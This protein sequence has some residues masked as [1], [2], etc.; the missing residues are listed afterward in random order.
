ME[1]ILKL[2]KG[3]PGR[4][5][6]LS[7]LF[8]LLLTGFVVILLLELPT[9]SAEPFC[10]CGDLDDDGDIDFDDYDIMIESIVTNPS[11]PDIL[12][13]DTDEDGVSDTLE[14]LVEAVAGNSVADK[15]DK[16][17]FPDVDCSGPGT[18]GAGFLDGDITN[19][20]NQGDGLG[21]DIYDLL[22][23]H[24]L[25]IG[26]SAFFGGV[27][28]I[29][30]KDIDG[31]G[32]L[33][34]ADTEATGADCSDTLDNNGNGD[35]DCADSDC[36]FFFTC[37][38]TETSCTDSVDNDEDTLTDC[39]DDDCDGVGTCEFATE[40]TCNDGLDNDGDGL[41][42]DTGDTCTDGSTAGDPDCAPVASVSR[43]INGVIGS[44]VVDD[45][46]QIDLDAVNIPPGSTTITE[47]VPPGWTVS[48]AGG[49][50]DMGSTLEFD[51]GGDI[52]IS[53]VLSIPSCGPAFSTHP[54]S[55]SYSGAAS[56]TVTGDTDIVC[57]SLGG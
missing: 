6:S 33:D 44:I 55:G 11:Y 36:S 43:T 25:A 22:F 56:G 41:C 30:I 9:V 42:D 46:V 57:P 18:S 3:D 8:T 45:T 1:D 34:S 48:D 26:E 53:Y 21:G 23:I 24:K 50:A 54:V 28:C 29:G 35:T 2:S 17:I 27:E 32:I 37:G 40:L 12:D 51:I 5:F 49:G 19:T 38:G 10:T 14:D 7:I 16:F 31:D 15:T 39:Q 52:M 4:I 13:D 47:D 20:L